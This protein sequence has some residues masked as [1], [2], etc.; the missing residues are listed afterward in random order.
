MRLIY[1]NVQIKGRVSEVRD[2]E[3]VTSMKKKLF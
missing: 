2:A 3:E 1:K